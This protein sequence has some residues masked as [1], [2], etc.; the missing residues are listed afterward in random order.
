MPGTEMGNLQ[1]NLTL[2]VENLAQIAVWFSKP[3]LQIQPMVH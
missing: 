3:D 2:R 1:E